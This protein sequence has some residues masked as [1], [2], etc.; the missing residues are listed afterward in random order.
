MPIRAPVFW[1][2]LLG[3]SLAAA[4]GFDLERQRAFLSNL[5]EQGSVDTAEA[6]RLLDQA[7]YRQDII[8]AISRPAEAKPWYSYRPIFLDERRIEAGARFWQDH[9]EL[10]AQLAEEFQVEAEILV[11][12]VGVETFYGRHTGRYRV[13]D[14]LS[15]LAFSYPPRAD[16]FARELEQFFLLAAEED[17]DPLTVSGSYAGAMG[18]PQFISSSYRHYAVDGDG[19]GQRDLLNNTA[20]ALASVA[21]YFRRHGWRQGEPIAYRTGPARDG[22]AALAQGGL[23]P[24]APYRELQ[25]AGVTVEAELDPERPA[26]L[27]SLEQEDGPEYWVTFNNFY[28]ITR[29]N[30]SPL[31]AMAVHQLAQAIKARYETQA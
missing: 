24:S 18:M 13:L 30:H 5:A 22:W 2:A 3:S 17:L 9:A 31:Y 11:A 1:A 20:D 27:V 25:A 6:R 19:D 23:K 26:R 12:I 10:L 21:N 28:V 15:T 4:Q 7:E 8:D 29:Y 16:F 14:A